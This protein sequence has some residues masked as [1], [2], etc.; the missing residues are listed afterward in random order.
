MGAQDPQSDAIVSALA[1][2]LA[3]SEIAR[4]PQ[5]ARFL[6]Y[7]VQKTLAGEDQSIKAYSIAVDVFGR[8]PDF[9]PQ[10]DPIVRVQARRLR[11]LL[12][13][14]Y[15]GP[16]QDEAVQ[17]RLPVG[18]Y[19]PDFIVA[20]AATEVEPLALAVA[21][22]APIGRRLSGGPTVSWYV[23]AVLAV[24]L[25]VAAYSITTWGP[26]QQQPAT[27]TG[28]LQRPSVSIVEFQNLALTT[29]PVPQVAGLAIELVTDL[30]QFDNVAVSYRGGESAALVENPP[31]SDFILTGIVRPDG[32]VVQYSAILTETLTGSV[33]WNQTLS[34]LAAEAAMPGVLDKVSKAFS[35]VLGSPR[36]PLHASARTLMATALPNRDINLYLCRVLFDRYRETGAAADAQSA[37]DCLAA[38]PETDKQ[39]SVALAASASLTVEFVDVATREQGL[40]D[41]MRL[42]ADKLFHAIEL[43]PI[44]GFVWEQK[45]RMH[46]ARGE[47]D[48]AQ[49]DYASSV[50]LNPASADALAAFARLLA[51]SGGLREAEPMARD[52]AE[53]SPNAPDWYFGVPTLLALRDQHLDQAVDYAER[54]A[55][56]D[57]ELGPVLAIMAGQQAGASAL[58]NRYLPQVLDMAAFRAKGVLPRLRER[59]SD[60]TLIDQIRTSLAEAGVP[61]VS[62]TRSY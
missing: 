5:L 8:G 26:R 36:G 33:V 27:V 17:I 43:D 45:A 46:E 44:S 20:E 10:A 38:L 51:L 47:L 39:T 3:W 41:R 59:I 30:E 18:R 24:A 14:F 42:A 34:V 23:L 11:G 9:D 12:E 55:Q 7:I 56:A 49:A 31:N 6:E 32:A 37:R 60:D 35:L 53:G 4:S 40:E 16:G 22:T 19:V 61:W 58:V 57:R 54:Y 1:R 29:L 2:L 15:R 62:L 13:D 28:L 48:Q 52:A 21:Q 50:Q 25:V